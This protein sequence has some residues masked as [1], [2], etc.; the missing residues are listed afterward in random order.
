[1]SSK[2][3]DTID[4]Y[5]RE[6]TENFFKWLVGRRVF[7]LADAK[8]N[9][10]MSWSEPRIQCCINQLLIENK[11]VRSNSSTARKVVHEV[12]ADL[13]DPIPGAGTLHTI[14]KFIF[15]FT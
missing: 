6:D 2:V 7:S 4:K 10:F 14:L 8:N 11:V 15:P 5:L 9:E 13:F 12:S 1:M 3:C